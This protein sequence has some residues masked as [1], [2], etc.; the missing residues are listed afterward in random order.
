MAYD[1]GGFKELFPGI[2]F[3]TLVATFG[4]YV[5]MYRG[6]SILTVPSPMVIL[7]RNTHSYACTLGSEFLLYSG[8]ADASKFS[9][10]K[11]LD[12]NMSIALV[13]GGATE[14]L[15]V[16]PKKDVLYLKNRKGFIKLGTLSSVP[17]H[18]ITEHH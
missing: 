1:K 17:L 7:S 8:M 5:P 15:Y 16:S 4:F 14:A 2:N 18:L 13:P 6:E 10:K 9:A 11:L 12:D 3:K